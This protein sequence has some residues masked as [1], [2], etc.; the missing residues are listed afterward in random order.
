[1]SCLFFHFAQTKKKLSLFEK[2]MAAY[3]NPSLV[4][5]FEAVFGDIRLGHRG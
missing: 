4:A 2:H 3:D 5:E 1:V